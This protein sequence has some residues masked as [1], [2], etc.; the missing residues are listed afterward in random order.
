[1]SILFELNGIT[2]SDYESLAAGI[3]PE[4]EVQWTRSSSRVGKGWALLNRLLNPRADIHPNLAAMAVSGGIPFQNPDEVDY[5]GGCV[6]SPRLV[7]MIAV[8]LGQVEEEDLRR[9][10]DA[11]GTTG[12]YGSN[13]EDPNEFDGILYTFHALRDFYAECAEN[14]DGVAKW[15]G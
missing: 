4:E 8:A 1:M 3:L 2:P 14:G 5:G 15:L 10:Y 6:V 12:L 11:F 9:R 7:A 13:P